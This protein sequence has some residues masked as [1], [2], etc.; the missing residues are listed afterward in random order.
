MA[1]RA[2][3]DRQERGSVAI[4]II[5]F[6][7]MLT[8]VAGLCIQGL[9]VSQVGATAQQAARDGARAYAMGQ[10][11]LAAAER[12]VPGWM[13]VEDITATSSSDA[14]TVAVTLRVPFGLPSITTGQVVVTRDAVMPRS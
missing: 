1:T 9:Y 11:G 7:A 8:I 13:Q 4:E 14:V 3:T 12:Q 2:R 6:V 5:G 10:D